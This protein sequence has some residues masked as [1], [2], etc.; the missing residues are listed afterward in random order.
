MATGFQQRRELWYSA[1]GLK[2][3][4]ARFN[5]ALPFLEKYIK[6]LEF[7]HS[8][9]Y[10]SKEHKLHI[11]ITEPYHTAG[12]ALSEV[13]K[14]A[15]CAGVDFAFATGA[16]GSGLWYPGSCFTLLLARHGTEKLLEF[17]AQA[18]PTTVDLVPNA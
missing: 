8:C 17:Y 18:L 14:L 4:G 12:Q 3:S 11:L 10:Y 15:S 7:D 6:P 1:T 2:Y 5:K 13:K 9:V 16:H